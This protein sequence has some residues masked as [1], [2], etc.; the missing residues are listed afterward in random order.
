MDVK[1]EALRLANHCDGDNGAFYGSQ[2]SDAQTAIAAARSEGW[3]EELIAELAALLEL[4]CAN[5]QVGAVHALGLIVEANRPEVW[6]ALIAILP[7]GVWRSSRADY[8]Y[9]EEDDMRTPG[10]VSAGLLGRW[11]V[12]SAVDALCEVAEDRNRPADLR[13]PMIEALWEMRAI[14]AEP[15]ISRLVDDPSSTTTGV[16]D[17]TTFHVGQSARRILKLFQESDS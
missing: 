16:Y 13:V 15:T 6:K 3:L 14:G 12:L 11:K 8:L 9:A 10:G 17:R 2:F 7:N 1:A 4:P 5:L